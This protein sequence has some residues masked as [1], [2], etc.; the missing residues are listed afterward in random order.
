MFRYQMARRVGVNAYDADKLIVEVVAVN[1]EL[2][3]DH[4]VPD[5]ASQVATN[6]V[7]NGDGTNGVLVVDDVGLASNIV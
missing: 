7:T 2:S 6:H 4:L 3:D 1:G 5:T